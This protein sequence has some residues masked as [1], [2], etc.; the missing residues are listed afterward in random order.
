MVYQVPEALSSSDVEPF[1]APPLAILVSGIF[2]TLV[3]ALHA[4]LPRAGFSDIRPAHSINLFRV[5]DAQGTRPSELARRAGVTPQAMAEIVR[6]LEGRG[7]VERIPDES[8]GRGRIVRL[9]PRGHEAFD[10]AGRVFVELERHWE[11]Q[12]GVSRMAQLREMLGELDR[13]RM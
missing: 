4:A 8:D 7:Y 10:V 1:Q 3:E 2:D 5:I 13:L 12:L 9:T 11:K 6:Y